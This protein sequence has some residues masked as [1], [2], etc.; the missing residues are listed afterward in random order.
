MTT[1]LKWWGVA[2][3]V[4]MHIYINNYIYIYLLN[5]LSLC[6]NYTNVH[7]IVHSDA[8]VIIEILNCT[9]M[10]VVCMHAHT[11]TQTYTHTRKHI[12]MDTQYD[13]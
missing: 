5:C 1:P 2:I 6:S 10:Y 9:Y 3:R 8:T 11:H 7:D 4:H 13:T 12:S